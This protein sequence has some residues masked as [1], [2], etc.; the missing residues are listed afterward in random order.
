MNARF[1]AAKCLALFAGL[2]S[3]QVPI[4]ASAEER[5]VFQGAVGTSFG[6]LNRR[7]YGEGDSRRFF[8]EP[9]FHAYLALPV[10]GL[11]GRGTFH[12]S[13]VWQ[14][15]EMPQSLRVT[16]RD[17]SAGLGMGLVYDWYVIPAVT[18]GAEFARRDIKIETSTPIQSNGSRIS[19][20]EN[21]IGYFTQLGVGVPL[22][23]G[24]MVF[25]PFYR[26]RFFPK[27]EREG[28]AYG[29]DVSVQLF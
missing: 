8:I 6:F 14:Q 22:L 13:Y 26:F 20:T 19:D 10:A 23:H 17:L 16:E 4:H 21:L 18:V 5:S 27:D 28:A 15:P 11:F 7:D 12:F 2:A 9:A 1:F 29:I 24:L 3:V 25:E